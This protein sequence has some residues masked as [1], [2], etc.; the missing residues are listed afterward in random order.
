M[1]AQIIT[2]GSAVALAVASW[3][4]PL[5]FPHVDPWVAK[6][7]LT[8]SAVMLL[9][10]FVLWIAGL[11][12]KPSGAGLN[13]VT[14]G[15]ASPVFRDVSGGVHF[16]PPA[17]SPPAMQPEKSPQGSGGI[18]PVHFPPSPPPA[19]DH[20]FEQLVARLVHRLGPVPK[21]HEAKKE[22]FRQIELE[23]AD[24]VHS[25]RM[26]VWGRLRDNPRDRIR[27]DYL[28]FARFDIQGKMVAIRHPDA[29]RWTNYTDLK[30]DGHEV[31]EAW[32]TPLRTTNDGR[33]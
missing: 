17:P 5:V 10:I 13:Q 30:F 20:K 18:G 14:H 33:P 3:A 4:L 32:P 22:F 29:V 2:G 23:I 28:R 12:G 31:E 21:E 27:Q 1:R 9:A 19:D 7:M 6:G 8:I 16:H 24:K 15:P 26:A 25:R 11:K